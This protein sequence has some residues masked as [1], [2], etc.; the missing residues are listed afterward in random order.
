MSNLT[1]REWLSL[2]G[3]IALAHALSVHAQ[4]LP[5]SFGVAAAPPCAPGT[6]PTPA[7]PARG[8]Q[9]GAPV[10]RTVG[11]SRAETRAIG[12]TG[13]VI[14]LKCGLIAGAFVDIWTPSGRGRQVTDADGRYIFDRVVMPEA[15]SAGPAVNVRVEVPG[16][17]TLVTTLFL[18][19]ELIAGTASRG[20]SFDPL[21][22]MTLAHGAV[23]GRPAACSFDV[24]LDL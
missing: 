21:L 7:R 16:K 12:L 23:D 14:G 6:K 20:S 24:I 22:Q 9:P 1:R 17:A 15:A 3:A 13:T 8:F 11:A 5:A 18:P 4:K 10:T 19:A 2:S